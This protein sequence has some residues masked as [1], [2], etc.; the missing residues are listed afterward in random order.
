MKLAELEQL[1]TGTLRLEPYEGWPDSVHELSPDEAL[2]LKTALAAGRPLLVRGEPGTGKT[3]LARA[4]AVAL[5]RHFVSQT[6]DAH[7]E[8]RDLFWTL[9]AVRRL[10]EAQLLAATAAGLHLTRVSE[11]SSQN[12]AKPAPEV[13]T[14]PQ[15]DRHVL[16][17]ELAERRFVR[18]GV[19]WWAFDWEDAA[20]Q[21]V[22]CQ[23]GDGRKAGRW[24]RKDK[25]A[26]SVVLLDE[27]DKADPVLP[28]AL[29]EALG[30]GRFDGP[31]GR[32]VVAAVSPEPLVVIT[33]N[34]ERALPNAFVRRC[35]VLNLRLPAK[36]DELAERMIVRG[37]QHG[38]LFETAPT[39]VVLERCAGL[40]VDA[41]QRA[42]D[43]TQPP[44][45]QA[46]FLD[47]LRAVCGLTTDESQRL[48][49]LD[50]LQRFVMHKH[51]PLDANAP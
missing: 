8:A 7:T 21:E 23:G 28:N 20:K 4:A 46:E 47:L 24:V 14:A 38:V 50:Q 36:D 51:D 5:K 34:R 3:Q 17:K 30:T 39:S 6:L 15:Y 18:P 9:D 44:P 41:R 25:K 33:T 31:Q 27:I 10:A 1:V 2:A 42:R 26:G 32:G 11:A 16:E 48:A 45:G 22:D 43:R 40:L 49:L 29:L 35:A 12:A 37:Q 13:S 19:L